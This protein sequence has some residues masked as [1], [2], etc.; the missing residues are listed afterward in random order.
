MMNFLVENETKNYL[1][2]ILKY[3]II[4]D[5]GELLLDDNQVKLNIGCGIV[6][7][8]GYINIDNFDNSIVD[9]K[10]DAE[11]LNFNENSVDIIESYHLIEHFDYINCKYV[12]SEWFRVLKSNGKLIIETP[13]LVKSLKK[14]Q[15]VDVETK[16][17][18]LNWIFGIDNQGMS[19]KTGFTFQLLKK[20]LEEIGFKNISNKKPISHTYE[21]GLRIECTKPK[22]FIN[23]QFISIFRKEVKNR[24][25][26]NESNLLNSLEEQCISQICEIFFE[27]FKN[28]KKNAI[29]KIISKSAISNPLIS[30]VFCEKC[31][32]NNL[33][34]KEEIKKELQI[35]KHLM[36]IDFHKRLFTLWKN[37]KKEI[38]RTN[39]IFSKFSDQQRSNILKMLEN[40]NI[41][42]LDYITN[43]NPEDIKIFN[44]HVVQIKS[45]ILSNIGIKEFYNKDYRKA[46][47]SL[48]NSISLFPDSAITHWNIAKLG[49]IT[50]MDRVSIKEHY[51]KSL[52]LTFDKNIKNILK[53]EIKYFVNKEYKKISLFPVAD[54]I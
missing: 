47:E 6:Y 31:I 7:K 5:L 34:K 23:Y 42:N 33:I 53:Q 50:D 32:E 9:E 39:D 30:L 1:E 18:T 8:P 15:N 14:F 41:K 16:K 51:E 28:N 13:D 12:L 38:G 46:M 52:M 19:H 43:L 27:C 25:N 20:L 36:K 49:I 4:I 29:R 40:S 48:L 44:F 24:I 3:Q 37:Y 35:I 10:S 54:M 17:R 22:N 21:P 11:N 2:I 45:L 26:I